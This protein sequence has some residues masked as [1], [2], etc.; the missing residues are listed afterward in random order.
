MKELHPECNSQ[1]L[2]HSRPMS[3]SNRNLSK[4]LHW[5]SSDSVSSIN[6]GFPQMYGTCRRRE[7]ELLKTKGDGGRGV[8]ANTWGTMTEGGLPR[9]WIMYRTIACRLKWCIRNSLT[10]N[11]ECSKWELMF[12][13]NS[14]QLYPMLF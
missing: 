13:Q 8:W 1:E 9:K 6:L 4:A 5:R 14:C 11:V 3:R 10:P 7:G 2:T 12:L